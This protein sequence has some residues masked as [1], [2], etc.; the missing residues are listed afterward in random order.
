MRRKNINCRHITKIQETHMIQKT[1][2]ELQ[3]Q[4]PDLVWVAL[5]GPATTQGGTKQDKKRIANILQ[6]VRAQDD[7]G[8]A[9]LMEAHFANPVWK[10]EVFKLLEQCKVFNDVSIHSCALGT[11]HYNLRIMTNLWSQELVNWACTCR[12]RDKSAR[13]NKSMMYRKVPASS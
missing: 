12:A 11:I 8:R 10:M 9:V 2:Q 7:A 6:L 1:L 13:L 3:A 5:Q 4:K